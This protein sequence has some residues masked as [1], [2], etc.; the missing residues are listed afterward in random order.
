MRPNPILAA[1]VL[2]LC[3]VATGCNGGGADARITQIQ[4]LQD[5]SEQQA[6]LL[7]QKDEQLATQA[8]RIQELQG[9]TAE[10]A[11]DNLVQ[12]ANIEIDRLSGGY[13]DNHDG[14]DEGVVVYLRLL[15]RDGDAIKAIGSAR[16]RLFDL[17]R[18]EGSQLV[19]ESSL[20]AA[21]M[22]PLWFGRLLT[23]HYTIKVPWSGGAK[24]A[25]HKSITVVV[26]FTDLLTGK[27]FTAQKV[28]EVSGAAA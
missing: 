18:P 7:A 28:V 14:V 1:L 9:L 13:D 21:A 6:R 12:V 5:K 25:D 15:D 10:R 20:D 22:R 2:S 23:Y 8:K 3:L 19:G 11:I 26:D 17:A 16:V 4:Q 27:T 24:R